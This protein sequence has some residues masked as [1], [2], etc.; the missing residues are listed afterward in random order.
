MKELINIVLNDDWLKRFCGGAIDGL[1]AACGCAGAEAIYCAPYTEALK[2]ASAVMGYHLMFYPDWIGF[3]RGDEDYIRRN[4]GTR[5]VMEGYFRC[6]TPDEYVM[7]LRADMDM[8]ER[9]HARYAVFHV[10]DVSSREILSFSF[11]HTNREIIKAS[12]ELLN[13]AM[14]GR[15]YHFTLLLENLFTPGMT[16]VDPAQ[17]ELALSLVNYSDVGIMLDTGHLMITNPALKTER[18]AWGYVCGIIKKH[19]ALKKH[20]SGLHI[21]K[22]LAGDA[23]SA[24]IR[25][26][27]VIEKDFYAAFAQ[28]YDWILRIDRHLPAC[29]PAAR[30]VLELA[31]P[32]YIVHE[33]A[34]ADAPAKLAAVSE[35]RRALG[36]RNAG[37]ASF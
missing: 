14:A 13:R 34:A 10:S 24:L 33:L 11:E 2:G 23:I 5:E 7:R 12:A 21:H 18:E 8:A 16:L 1:I 26:K 35:Q 9:L 28:S 37:S 15:E 22:S 25:E 6:K 30:D 4:Y 17:T 31:A 36:M 3:F 32:K 29:D 27:P 19:G 20:I